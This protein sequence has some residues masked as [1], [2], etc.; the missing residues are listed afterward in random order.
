MSTLDAV[1]RDILATIDSHD[2]EAVSSKLAPDVEI[3]APG[4]EGRGVQAVVGFMAPFLAAFPDIHHEIANT[5][6][7]GDTIAIELVITG[8]QT[9]PLVGPGGELPPTGK[10]VRFRAA[11]VWRVE[12]GRPVSYRVYFDTASLMAQLGVGAD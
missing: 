9:E 7:V 6:E 12:H 5:V 4:F 2:L 10:S 3:M 1:A 11:N 8:T